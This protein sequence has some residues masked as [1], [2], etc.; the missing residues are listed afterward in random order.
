MYVQNLD[1]EMIS[2]KFPFHSLSLSRLLS[3]LLYLDT[4]NYECYAVYSKHFESK[5]ER[6]SMT[7]GQFI[8]FIVYQNL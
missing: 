5:L 8:Q 4:H 6:K 3:A 2:V 7:N 1:R